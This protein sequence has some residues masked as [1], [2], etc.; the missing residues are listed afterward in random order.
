MG[1]RWWGSTGCCHPIS[2]TLKPTECEPCGQ[3]GT[4]V[5]WKAAQPLTWPR[6]QAAAHRNP[7]HIGA[8]EKTTLVWLMGGGQGGQWEVKQRMGREP[9][10]R[11]VPTNPSQLLMAT[12]APWH[13]C[14]TPGVDTL[15]LQGLPEQL[16]KILLPLHR[17]SRHNQ[18]A[19][20][21]AGVSAVPPRTQ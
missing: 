20:W 9:D 15:S 8:K 19:G 14:D 5:F 2:A 18:P 1:R 21:A 7:K 3:W 17:G 10:E 11:L 13:A 12:A 16:L 6:L 4:A